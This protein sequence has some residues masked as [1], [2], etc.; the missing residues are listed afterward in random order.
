MNRYLP[1]GAPTT[2]REAF[3]VV[4]AAV[5]PTIDQLKM[6]V[7]LEASGLGGYGD[8]AEAS[9][10]ADVAGL[11]NRNGQEELA[12]AHRVRK[13][14]QAL[15]GETFDIPSL[16]ENPYYA[17]ASG[18]TVTRAMLQGIAA[19]EYNGEKLYETWADN[20]G[21]EEAARLFRLNGKEEASHGER[22]MQAAALLPE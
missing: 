3:A 9:G 8:L 7:L 19:A 11:L 20:I 16:D 13:A 10:N 22:V 1:A 21:N 4:N 5:K 14:I 17:K 18:V 15:T 6:M 2:S 12:H